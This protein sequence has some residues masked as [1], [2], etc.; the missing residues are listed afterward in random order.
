MGGFAGG[1]P[2]SRFFSRC[3][4]RCVEDVLHLLAQLILPVDKFVD[5]AFKVLTHNTLQAVTVKA[6]QV[7]QKLI[8]EH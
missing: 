2:G 8:A 3:T 6:D 4:C 5:A 1:D 7:G